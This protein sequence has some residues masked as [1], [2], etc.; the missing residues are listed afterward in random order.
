MSPE[1]NCR[2]VVTI[3]KTLPRRREPEGRERLEQIWSIYGA[4]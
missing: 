3:P 2:L 1:Y 4:S